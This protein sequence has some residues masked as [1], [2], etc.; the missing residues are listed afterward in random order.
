ADAVSVL[1]TPQPLRA[2]LPRRTST[3][4]PRCGR[5]D[6]LRPD[7]HGGARRRHRRPSRQAR[8]RPGCARRWH[9][10]GGAHDRRS[11]LSPG[12]SANTRRRTAMA[13]QLNDV[14]IEKVKEFEGMVRANPALGKL[15]FKVT[16]SW[17]HGTKVQVTVG[18][19]HALGQN[20]FSRTRRFFI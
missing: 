14:N 19:I 17:H 8:A 15:T 2:A 18:A 16:S 1:S 4:A 7:E 10:E 20:L 9:R 3:G 11:P 12:Q 13:E 5:S 6:G